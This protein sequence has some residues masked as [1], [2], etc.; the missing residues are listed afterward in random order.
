[1]V[2]QVFGRGSLVDTDVFKVTFPRYDL[3]VYIGAVFV[4]PDLA[5]TSWAAFQQIGNQ[6]RVMGDLVLLE[7]EVDPVILKLMENGLEVTAL[8]NHLLRE[9]PRVMFLHI[10]GTGDPVLLALGVRSALFLTTT[11]FISPN[12]QQVFP[13]LDWS[14]VEDIFGKRG[15]RR[16]R[17]LL[18]SI[19]RKETITE[20]GVQI[21]PTMG[22]AHAINFQAEGQNIVSTTG[23]FVL[24]ANE[25]NPVVRVLEGNGISVT[26]IHNHMLMET[27]RLFY[28]H[29]WATGQ[30]E[31]LA[32][33]LKLALEQ[34]NSMP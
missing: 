8:H 24:L 26:A 19:P 11:P 3:R 31:R 32:R 18:M 4:E 28:L 9:T 16:G 33:V 5:F 2:K 34:T 1:M 7:R 10:E 14:V 20:N 23:D 30:V 6:S 27:P 29:Y 22:V 25:V 15:Q 12:P 21:S 17:V 13:P